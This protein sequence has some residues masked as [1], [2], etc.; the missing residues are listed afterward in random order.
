MH[1]NLP[2]F[3]GTRH[4]ISNRVIGQHDVRVESMFSRFRLEAPAPNPVQ[5]HT[6][7]NIPQ[8]GGIPPIS[9]FPINSPSSSFNARRERRIPVQRSK[10]KCLPQKSASS[11]YR[12]KRELPSMTRVSDMMSVERHKNRLARSR[13]L[14]S[15]TRSLLL[16]HPPR[17]KLRFQ[18]QESIM[19]VARPSSFDAYHGSVKAPQHH[20]DANSIPQVKSGRRH[21]SKASDVSTPV[22]A[23]IYSSSQSASHESGF[24]LVLGRPAAYST[25]MMDS[26]RRP[27][28]DG[29]SKFLQV[30][31]NH[32]SLYPETSLHISI[33]N[34]TYP[35]NF[36]LSPA[37]WPSVQDED[38]RMDYIDAVAETHSAYATDAY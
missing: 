31:G 24:R 26:T 34:S 12:S 33:Q 15:P 6:T 16:D 22:H 32:C 3:A 28:D 27:R 20:Q 13:L 17:F 4:T 19:N 7:Q 8:S 11:M 18:G 1:D 2:G 23:P 25:E 14:D 38:D 37:K 5:N 21:S 30:S 10:R 36:P 35:V 9:S 29:Q